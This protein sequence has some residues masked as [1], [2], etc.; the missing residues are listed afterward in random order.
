MGDEPSAAAPY[1]AFAHNPL[2]PL[3]FGFATFY[4]YSV[5]WAWGRAREVNALLR[6][7]AIPQ[8]LLLPAVAAPIVAG[9]WLARAAP[10]LVAPAVV[11][12]IMLFLAVPGVLLARLLPEMER[13]ARRPVRERYAREALWMVLCPPWGQY[14]CQLRLNEI[15]PK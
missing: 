5:A 1:G 9:G 10:P 8:A 11:L 3:V 2:K 14:L 13:L 15:W 12:S 4:L 7:S 6:R